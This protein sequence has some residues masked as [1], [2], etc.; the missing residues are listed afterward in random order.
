MKDKGQRMKILCP[1]FFN[2]PTLKTLNAGIT[3]LVFDTIQTG[4]I[5]R[6]FVFATRQIHQKQSVTYQSGVQRNAQ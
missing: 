4:E 6:L 3:S 1:L 5:I 2:A